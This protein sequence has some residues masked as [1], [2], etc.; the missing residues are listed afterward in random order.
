MNDRSD[1]E[2]A[3]QLLRALDEGRLDYLFQTA[4]IDYAER[5][6]LAGTSLALG[7]PRDA[8]TN[9][10]AAIRRAQGLTILA[11]AWGDYAAW[12]TISAGMT[13]LLH[14]IDIRSNFDFYAN[15]ELPD[16]EIR[17][18]QNRILIEEVLPIG[19]TWGELSPTDEIALAQAMNGARRMLT[20]G[21]EPTTEYERWV[22]QFFNLMN[23][24]PE[25]AE[26]PLTVHRMQ[27]LHAMLALEKE[28]GGVFRTTDVIAQP[29]IGLS[30]DG[31]GA[32][33]ERIMGEM[34]AIAAYGTSRQKPYVH[35]MI[36]TLVY[37]YWIRRIQPFQVA[38]ALFARLVIHIFEYQQGYKTLPLT[39]LT[40]TAASEWAVP[41]PWAGEDRRVDATTFVAKRLRLFLNAYM[42][43]EREL[44]DATKR[45]RALCSRFEGL[46]INHRQARILDE[47]MSL[48]T[49][50]FTIK[51]HA[52]SRGLAYETARQDFLQLVAAGYLEQYKR[53]RLFEFRLAQDA[54]KKLA[55]R[56]G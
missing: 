11:G 10:V 20:E 52:R 28:T 37:F 4:H 29:G 2:S 22:L 30:A 6:G 9:L 7:L 45:Y 21:T 55:K 56:L 51:R 33:A 50:V 13:E 26:E 19:L 42:E 14:E 38:N 39:P 23:R 15:T 43:A 35:P 31:S 32:P 54:E 36:K 40:R 18:L 25:L 27:E 48:P 24:L 47:A 44:A 1:C 8:V 34:S 17:A 41:P 5:D 53:G 16:D 46:D 49:T 3:A 12:I